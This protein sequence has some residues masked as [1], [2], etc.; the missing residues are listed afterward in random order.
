MLWAVAVS[1]VGFQTMAVLALVTQFADIGPAMFRV[2]Q[3]V[4]DLKVLI[5]TAAFGLAD[6]LTTQE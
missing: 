6:I 4:I 2:F 5:V 1:L 3:D